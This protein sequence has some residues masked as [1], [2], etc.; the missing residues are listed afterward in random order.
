MITSLVSTF[1]GALFG[2]FQN[3]LEHKEDSKKE[4]N[5]AK[6]NADKEIALADKQAVISQTELKIQESSTEQEKSKTEASM[7][8]SE[9]EEYKAFAEAVTQTSSLWQN[10]S[11]WGNL[12]NF[13]TATLRPIVTYILLALVFVVT[14]KIIKGVE[15][16][17]NHLIVFDLVLAEFSAVMSYWFVRRS[18]EKRNAPQFSASKK[19]VKN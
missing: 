5:I 4:I 16:S 9:T 10:N 8:K 19:K 12:A 6:I 3:Y 15:V 2:G 17:E 13:I 7:C 18:F 11:N 14:M 1:C